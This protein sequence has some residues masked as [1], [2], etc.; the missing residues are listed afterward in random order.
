VLLAL[1]GSDEADVAAA[2]LQRLLE[3]ATSLRRSRF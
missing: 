1:G 2:I 3:L